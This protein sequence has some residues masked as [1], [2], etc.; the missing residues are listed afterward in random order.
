MN[1]LDFY[2]EDGTFFLF[3]ESDNEFERLGKEQVEQTI[4]ENAYLLEDS[5]GAFVT[6]AG[7]SLVKIMTKK[8][9]VLKKMDAN[10]KNNP[11]IA[12]KL[13][14]VT[15]KEYENMLPC[16]NDP[17]KLVKKAVTKSLFKTLPAYMLA[18]AVVGGGIGGV[19]GR[20][21]TNKKADNKKADVEYPFEK[22]EFEKFKPEE[23]G[24]S[25]SFEPEKSKKS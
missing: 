6:K 23:F 4:L 24:P 16:K 2:N 7:K 8:I 18:G 15:K 3:E 11:K 14:K 13:V 19:V 21:L 25:K 10:A 9:E 1:I 17:V 20:K 12:K 5:E 22:F